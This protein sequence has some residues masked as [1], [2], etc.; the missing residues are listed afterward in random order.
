MQICEWAH[1]KDIFAKDTV[2]DQNSILIISSV[3]T[4]DAM[5]A[6]MFPISRRKLLDRN[7]CSY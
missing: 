5:E 2:D 6:R 4:N 7:I 3:Y 1:I